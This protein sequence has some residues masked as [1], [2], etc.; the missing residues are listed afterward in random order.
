MVRME[1]HRRHRG[2]L[3]VEET[4]CT[5]EVCKKMRKREGIKRKTYRCCG[6]LRWVHQNCSY[7]RFSR[8]C[9]RNSCESNTSPHQYNTSVVMQREFD[10]RGK[11]R[12]MFM[13]G[14]LSHSSLMCLNRLDWFSQANIPQTNFSS[15]TV[16]SK[17][18][19]LR[20][21]IWKRE[22]KPYLPVTSS[23]FPPRCM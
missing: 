20:Q 17:S 9:K 8:R 22:R 18:D 14:H 6:T 2:S 23:R 15:D 4:S 10:S 16:T 1:S 7:S 21:E 13:N 5:F 19:Q 11:D 3:R 12:S